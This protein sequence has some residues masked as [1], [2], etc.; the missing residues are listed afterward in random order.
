MGMDGAEPRPDGLSAAATVVSAEELDAAR[1]GFHR[2]FRHRSARRVFY[3]SQL[4]GFAALTAGS[5]WLFTHYTA[6]TW[7]AVHL[8]AL[9][10]FAAAIMLRLFAAARLQPVLSRLAEPECFPTY[11]ILCPLYREAGVTLDLAEALA[12]LDYPGIR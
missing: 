3:I 1:L 2:R 6:E 8:T 7:Q 10:L 4:F 12:R 5:A 11:T 9:T